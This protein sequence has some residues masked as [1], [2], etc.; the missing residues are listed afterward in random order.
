[1]RER[2]E[3]EREQ[4]G[5]ETLYSHTRHK[6]RK[7]DREIEKK[8]RAVR[9]RDDNKLQITTIH[10]ATTAN[11]NNNNNKTKNSIVA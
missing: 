7:Q 1:M 5:T 3:R 8:L 10:T 11:N 6:T 2:G 4:R 9:T